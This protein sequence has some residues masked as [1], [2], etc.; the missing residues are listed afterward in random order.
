MDHEVGAFVLEFVDQRLERRQVAVKI[1]HDRGS[2]HA[3]KTLRDASSTKGYWREP[4]PPDILQGI[5]SH[6]SGSRLCLE[7]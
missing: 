3:R 6:A 4:E 1:G 5:S 2:C 7:T